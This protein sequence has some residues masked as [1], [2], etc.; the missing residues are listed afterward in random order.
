[1]VAGACVPQ[2]QKESGE[3]SNPPKI[4]PEN[5]HISRDSDTGCKRAA[6]LSAGHQGEVVQP[7]KPAKGPDEE[8]HVILP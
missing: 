8:K 3:T 6:C 5:W 2:K 1:M 4:I 7:A